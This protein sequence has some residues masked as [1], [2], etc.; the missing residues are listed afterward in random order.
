MQAALQR[1]A[2]A[3]LHLIPASTETAGH[4]TTGQARFWREALREF[5][6]GLG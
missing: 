6:A 1:M 2:H 4:G 3:R 5:L